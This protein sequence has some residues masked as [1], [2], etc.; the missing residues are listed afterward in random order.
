MKP[1]CLDATDIVN[2]VIKAQMQGRKGIVVYYPNEDCTMKD[3]NR[4]L[5]TNFPL[6]DNK[7][8]LIPCPDDTVLEKLAKRLSEA[9]IRFE[10]HGGK[11]GT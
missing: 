9:E 8:I 2:A 3:L 5:K 11:D 1:T 10:T 4:V 7:I 6:D